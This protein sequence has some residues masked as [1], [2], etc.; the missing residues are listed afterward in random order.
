MLPN[1]QPVEH[2]SNVQCDEKRVSLNPLLGLNRA[3]CI[4]GFTKGVKA[5]KMKNSLV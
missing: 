5:G 4:P 1:I 3:V 2:L